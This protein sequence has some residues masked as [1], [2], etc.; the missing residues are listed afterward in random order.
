MDGW[1]MA[2]A[3]WWTKEGTGGICREAGGKWWFY[4]ANDAPRQGPFPTA[5]RAAY[6]ANHPDGPDPCAY[7]RQIFNAPA[8]VGGRV[9]IAYLIRGMANQTGTIKGADSQ[10]YV[11]M[12]GEKKP[13][14]F[15]PAHCITYFNT[16][17][18]T[19][20]FFGDT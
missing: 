2:E 14:P 20:A 1:V 9:R 17:G 11:L 12:D 16:D 8:Y 3:G 19:A 6:A 18:T 15:H 7:V 5:T 10:L 13:R 4:P